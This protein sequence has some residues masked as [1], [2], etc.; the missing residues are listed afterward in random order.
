MVT[1]GFEKLSVRA[2]P[3]NPPQA[4][5]RLATQWGL[6]LCIFCSCRGDDCG[7]T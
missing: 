7:K 6:S 1:V 5:C 2:A 4:E 3:T